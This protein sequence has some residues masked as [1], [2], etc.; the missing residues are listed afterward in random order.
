MQGLP[1]IRTIWL[2]VRDPSLWYIP[3]PV[4]P[5][6][7]LRANDAKMREAITALDLYSPSNWL[8]Y[9]PYSTR[10]IY[11]AML[12]LYNHF[13][14]HFISHRLMSILT[15]R[16]KHFAFHGLAPPK[17]RRLNPRLEQMGVL[18]TQDSTLP[19]PLTFWTLYFTSVC[20]MAMRTLSVLPDLYSL[21]CH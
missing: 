6:P 21:Y 11:N 7:V 20:I 4:P 8:W 2:A 19:A 16:K 13:A 18:E 15:T 1:N 10:V 5:N 12:I 17:T 3:S 9:C 14:C